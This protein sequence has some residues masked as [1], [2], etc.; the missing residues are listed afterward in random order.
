MLWRYKDVKLLSCTT[1]EINYKA[2]IKMEVKESFVK[3]KKSGENAYLHMCISVG[4][5]SRSYST[6]VNA[7][8]ALIDEQAPSSCARRVTS[9]P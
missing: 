9:R 6:N 7:K 5:H 3:S 4:K 8:C 1:K 2:K